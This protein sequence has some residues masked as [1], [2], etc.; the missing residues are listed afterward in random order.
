MMRFASWLLAAALLAGCASTPVSPPSTA[1]ATLHGD[2]AHPSATSGWLRTEL[3]FGTGAIDDPAHQ[4]SETT[5][6]AFLDREVSSRF[7]DGLSVFD[8]YG[9]WRGKGET[10]PR[11]LTS[12]VI[13]LLHP[14][15]AQQ[16]AAI[17]E[18]RAAWK[19]ETGHQSV[20]RVSQPAEV[21]F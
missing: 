7:P 11:R 8:I 14:D 15:T 3:Y 5:W 4:I 10:E 12:K 1:T 16:R 18:I 17:E 2:N 19:R 6:R 21:S 13:L 9:Q 20:L